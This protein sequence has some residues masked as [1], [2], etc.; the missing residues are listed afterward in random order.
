MARRTAFSRKAHRDALYSSGASAQCWTWLGIQSFEDLRF[1]SVFGA[2]FQT[3]FTVGKNA[4]VKRTLE[5]WP[6]DL[7][8]WW[9]EQPEQPAHIAQTQRLCNT[10][11]SPRLLRLPFKILRHLQ[12]LITSNFATSITPTDRP[13]GC[14]VNLIRA[15]RILVPPQDI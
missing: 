9:A 12:K 7:V 3:L 8:P 14:L 15:V 5:V 10:F 4:S 6:S 11:C 1:Y 13:L 2:V